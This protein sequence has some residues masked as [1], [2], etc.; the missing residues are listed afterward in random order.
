MNKS[1][2]AVY[3]SINEIDI[4]DELHQRIIIDFNFIN[5]KPY[6]TVLYFYLL[7]FFIAPLDVIVK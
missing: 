2:N 6:L 5:L 7:Q 3:E 1:N 4:Q